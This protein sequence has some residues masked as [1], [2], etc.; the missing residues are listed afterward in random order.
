MGLNHTQT[1]PQRAARVLLRIVQHLRRLL[2]LRL[3][4]RGGLRHRDRKLLARIHARGH[5]HLDLNA[6]RRRQRKHRPR[7]RPG[8][9]RDQE[10]R[11]LRLHSLRH[12]N[13][14]R[15]FYCEHRGAPSC[16]H[17]PER[18][19]NTQLALALVSL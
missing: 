12:Y 4:N 18:R 2:V 5:L 16:F 11:R 9:D 17:R 1:E 13:R 14:L 19:R 3:H 15:H 6:V 7:P 10:R 8:G